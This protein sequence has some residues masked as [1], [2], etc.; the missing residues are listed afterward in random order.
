MSSKQ[1]S[2]VS[3]A[4]VEVLAREVGLVIQ[5]LAPSWGW[6]MTMA[7]K[8]KK[9]F[10]SNNAEAHRILSDMRDAMFSKD[11]AHQLWHC[12]DARGLSLVS[13]NGRSDSLESM[14][15]CSPS[16]N[17]AIRMLDAHF[18]CGKHKSH[19]SFRYKFKKY[20]K[21]GW[22]ASM[23]GVSHDHGIY[24]IATRLKIN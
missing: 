14:A 24:S 11:K 7:D 6:F 16:M 10:A 19:S 21:A 12:V 20:W 23:V 22:P 9:K 1:I 17:Q 13:A 4:D 5:R 18:D 3:V 2:T 15:I 8:T